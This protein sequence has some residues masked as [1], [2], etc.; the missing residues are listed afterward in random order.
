MH[1]TRK[2]DDCWHLTQAIQLL[3]HI[4]TT[5]PDAVETGKVLVIGS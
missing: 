2:A 1:N 5:S 3:E 4:C